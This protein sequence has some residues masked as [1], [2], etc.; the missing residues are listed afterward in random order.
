[1]FTW[2]FGMLAGEHHLHDLSEEDLKLNLLVL[3]AP[4]A[5]E[6]VVKHKNSQG[7]TVSGDRGEEMRQYAEQILF[8]GVAGDVDL[9]AWLHELDLKRER[10]SS[11][12]A[13]P[14]PKVSAERLARQEARNK[15]RVERSKAIRKSKQV[16]LMDFLERDIGDLTHGIQDIFQAYYN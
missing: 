16:C 9:N 2:S 8:S 15:E 6:D 7:A 5:V 10:C 3:K 1:M 14:A 11:S 13:R 4:A 12:S